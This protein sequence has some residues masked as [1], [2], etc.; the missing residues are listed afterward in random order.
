M[1]ADLGSQIS[2]LGL[3]IYEWLKSPIPKIVFTVVLISGVVRLIEAII[4]A[5]WAVLRRH[6]FPRAAFQTVVSGL[7]ALV[8]LR[9]GQLLL[10][11]F[12]IAVPG[13]WLE[14]ASLALGLYFIVLA[15][16]Q[17]AFRRTFTFKRF[18]TFAAIPLGIGGILSGVAWQFLFSV[19]HKAAS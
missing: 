11:M 16:F 10:M 1:S 15:F 8:A 7:V 3:S 5:K 19:L 2:D 18:L 12:D 17:V 9:L 6:G 13:E 14:Q 4:D